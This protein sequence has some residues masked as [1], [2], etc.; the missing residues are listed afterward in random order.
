VFASGTSVSH[1]RTPPLESHPPAR[2]FRSD[3]LSDRWHCPCKVD[4]VHALR[5]L[6]ETHK[7]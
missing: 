1:K 5:G 3:P 7:P 4:N 6:V 2:V